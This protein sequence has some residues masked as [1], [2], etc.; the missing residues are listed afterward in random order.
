MH[1]HLVGAQEPHPQ[2]TAD[3]SS[4]V[5]S[6]LQEQQLQEQLFLERLTLRLQQMG[7]PSSSSQQGECVRGSVCVCIGDV[8]Q[9]VCVGVSTVAALAVW[10]SPC[11]HT[12]TQHL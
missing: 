2:P 5:A 3:A 4:M 8:V 6:P 9:R 12:P 1:V 10:Q 7:T 11:T